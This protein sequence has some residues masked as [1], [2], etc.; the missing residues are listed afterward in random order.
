[1]EVRNSLHV[2][3]IIVVYI[4]IIYIYREFQYSGILY[5]GISYKT[6]YYSGIP[7]VNVLNPA[8]RGDFKAWLC[9]GDLSGI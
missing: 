3:H 8:M 1:M 4:Y 5:S 6:L 2:Q 7:I 9:I